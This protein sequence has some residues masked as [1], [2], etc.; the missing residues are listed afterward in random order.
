[1]TK[2]LLSIGII[3]K[4]EIRCIERCLQSLR[5]LRDAIPCEVV[6]ADT[7]A[8]DGSRAVAEKYADILIDF[9]WINDFSAARNAVMDRCSGKWCMIIDCDEWLDENIE[10]YVAFLTTDEEYD[11]ASVIVR[12]YDTLE[13]DKGSSYSD[14]LS[15]RL[16]RMSTGIRYEGAV[17]EHWPYKGDLRTMMIRGAVF[18]HDGYVYQNQEMLKKKQERNM[19]L[20]QEQLE[21]D[22]DNLIILNQCVESSSNMPEQEGY[23]RRAVAGVNKKWPEWELFGAPIYRHAVRMAMRDELPEL[24][25]WIAKAEEMFPKSIFLRVEIAYFAFG[26]YWNTDNYTEAIRWGEKYLQG[27]EDYRVGNFELADLLASSLDKTDTYSRLSVSTVLASG[28]LHEGQPGK[29]VRLMERL[30]PG[31][32]NP[33]QILD[34]MNNFFCLRREFGVNIDTQ[35]VRFWERLCEPSADRDKAEQRKSVFVKAGAEV[36]TQEYRQLERRNPKFAAH[37]YTAFLPLAGKCGLGDAAVILEESDPRT[38]EDKLNQVEHWDETPIQALSHALKCGARFPLPGKP[39]CVEEMDALASRCASNKDELVSLALREARQSNLDDMRKLLW[40]RGL[41]MSAVRAYP[42]DDRERDED[43]GLELARAFAR[44]EGRFLPRCYAPEALQEDMLFMLPPMH[45]F[46]WYCSQAFEQLDRGDFAAC[47]QKLCDGLSQYSNAA[48]M[49]DFLLDQV[50]G[51]ERNTRIAAAPPELVALA[52]QVKVILARFAPDDP[53][54]MELKSSPVY[55][56]V[57]WLIETPAQPA[58]GTIM[59]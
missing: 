8:D 54:V 2:P 10:G 47:V 58:F 21:A 24:E 38:L 5:H 51:L 30:D 27:V 26:H 12:N 56:Q 50:A 4:N 46:G 6:M 40:A 25:G 31:E 11:F 48:S 9:P 57:A 19:A 32:M 37:A 14:F 29:C 1:M 49:V 28:Y 33:K 15:T 44:V 16:L 52:E 53:A 43:K 34:C 7:G 36:F 42:W 35:I 3:F 59:Q 18:H 20:L 39:M 22:P 23:L 41:V 45:R 17:H 55:Q 13:L